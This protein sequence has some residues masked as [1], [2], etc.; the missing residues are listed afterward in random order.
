[1]KALV[2]EDRFI[3]LW[4]QHLSATRVAKAIGISTQNVQQRRR[5]IEQRRNIRLITRDDNRPSYDQS[6]LI[7]ADRV[8]VKLKVKD[9]VVLVAG[10]QHYHPGNVPVMHRALC[11]L[12]KKMKP[13]AVVWNGDA[14]DGAT[15]SRH[16]SIGWENKPSVKDEIECVQDRS[17]EIMDAAPGAKKI[18]VAGNHDLRLE[19]RIAANLPELRGVRGVHLK[20][21]FGEWTPA[22]FV[23][24]NAGMPSHTEIRHREKGGA[25]ASYN[26]TVSSGVTLVTGHDHVAD[27]RPYDD[28]RGRR[29]GVR[30]GMTAD[31]ARDGPFVN[32]LEGRTPNWQSAFA[33]LTYKNYEL[34]M[35][36]L[37]L[38]WDD[39]SFQFRGEIIAV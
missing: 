6:M 20:D 14:F 9:G 19:C 32:Y 31:S 11:H 37:A 39:R 26:N 33:V 29:Y 38:R 7:T 12:A 24:V 36:E 15:I 22:W 21:F 17:K 8:E 28:R 4:N 5:A 30:H 35:P 10:D 27:V 34:L 16:P 1:M 3:E 2:S 18:W 25:H 13:F 23:S